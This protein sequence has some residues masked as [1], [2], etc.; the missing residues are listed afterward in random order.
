MYV[1]RKSYWNQI[2]F[3]CKCYIYFENFIQH[4]YSAFGVRTAHFHIAKLV[5]FGTFYFEIR[6]KSKFFLEKKAQWCSLL[7]KS[8]KIDL[9][10]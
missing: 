2:F 9:A 4:S 10:L 3:F 6:H 5:F 8:Y 7:G 1:K